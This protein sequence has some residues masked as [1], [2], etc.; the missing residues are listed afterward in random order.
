MYN[1]VSQCH[2]EEVTQI[3]CVQTSVGDSAAPWV[4]SNSRKRTV[5]TFLINLMK[6]QTSRS[7]V[8]FNMYKLDMW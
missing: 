6:E 2:F 5:S 3:L 7:I 8:Y 4:I 1:I